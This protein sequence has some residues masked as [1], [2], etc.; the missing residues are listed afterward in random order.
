MKILSVA[1]NE[2]K[3]YAESAGVTSIEELR[4]KYEEALKLTIKQIDDMNIMISSI[5]DIGRAEGA[6]FEQTTDID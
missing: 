6:Q 3:V 4:K 1:E 2:G 5:L